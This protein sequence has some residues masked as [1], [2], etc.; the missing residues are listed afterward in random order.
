M[1]FYIVNKLYLLCI[2]STSTLPEDK[3]NGIVT[4]VGTHCLQVH[5]EIDIS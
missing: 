4:Y 2:S 5:I 1:Q 3:I